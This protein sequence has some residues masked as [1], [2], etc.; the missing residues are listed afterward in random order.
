MIAVTGVAK[1]AWIIDCPF[2]A[3]GMGARPVKVS[4]NGVGNIPSCLVHQTLFSFFR[5]ACIRFM[6]IRKS[7]RIGVELAIVAHNGFKTDKSRHFVHV[8]P[9][10]PAAAAG[11]RALSPHRRP[12]PRRSTIANARACKSRSVFL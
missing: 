1:S 5:L 4:K 12:P 8:Q 2:E 9:H 10:V 11:A 7:F 3:L 6:D